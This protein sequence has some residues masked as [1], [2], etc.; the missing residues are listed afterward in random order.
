MSEKTNVVSIAK[1]DG[2]DL[3]KFRSKRAATVQNT[4]TLFTG[5]PVHSISQAKDFVR[6]HP[7]EDAYWSPE[8]CFVNVPVKGQKRE[9]LHLIDEDLAMEY[10]PAGRIKRGRLAL[11]SKPHD[12]FFLCSVPSQNLDNDWNSTNALA[13]DKAKTFWTSVSSRREEGVDGYKINFAR[14]ADC[15][16]DPQWPK[17]SLAEIISASFKDRMIDRADHPALLRLI[18]AKQEL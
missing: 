18:G 1:P 14:D 10:L 8:L 13:V 6:L 5:L 12:V 4:E 15:F 2:F 3:N 7:N 16:A 17:Q 11:A 9:T